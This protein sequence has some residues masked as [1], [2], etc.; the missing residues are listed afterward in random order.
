MET[1]GRYMRGRAIARN[2]KDLSKAWSGDNQDWWDWYLTL[3]E[4]DQQEKD[5]VALQPSDLPMASDEVLWSELAAAYPLLDTE[6]AAFRERGYIKLKEVLSAAAVGRL[7]ALLVRLL[8]SAFPQGDGGGQTDRF[9]TLEMSWLAD[10]EMRRFV[11]SPRL[12]GIAASLLDVPAVRLYHDNVLS[13]GPGCGR[14][15]WHFDDH[16]FP[17]ATD[18]VVTFWLPA[19]AVPMEMGPLAFAHPL[20]V[21]DL[22]RDIPFEV[23]GTSYDRQVAARFEAEKVA[24]DETPFDIGEAS[25]HH[26]RSFHTAGPNRTDR[27]RLVFSNTYFADGAHLV[28]RPTLVSGD[29][30]KF[31][32]GV[33]PGGLA[34]TPLNPICWPTKEHDHG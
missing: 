13:K 22:V 12:A 19:H 33:M 18:D 20:C 27:P 11:L 30:Q 14:T 1:T 21:S 26:N 6:R 34:A 2:A 24:V 28:E 17:L 9:Q 16:H 31:L 29:W 15:P 8:Q 10:E 25:F 5:V 32:P 23:M 7:N 3:A 4:N